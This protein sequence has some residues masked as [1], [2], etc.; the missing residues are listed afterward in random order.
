MEEKR[1]MNIVYHLYATGNLDKG[2]FSY[3]VGPCLTNR[4]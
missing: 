4:L 2:L 3:F 1:T